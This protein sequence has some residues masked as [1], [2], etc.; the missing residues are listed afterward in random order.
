MIRVAFDIGGTFTDF[1]LCDDATGSTHALKVPTSSANPGE[2]VIEGLEKL[3]AETGARGSAVDVVLH[4][5][6][7]ATNAVLERKGAKTGLITTQGFRDVLIIGRQKRYETYDMYIDKSE[8]LVARRHIV[9]VVERVAPDGTVVTSLDKDSVQR[10]IDAMLTARRETVAVSLLHAYA[11]PEHERQIR[12]QFA[13]RAPELLISISSEISPKFREY[14]RTNT[15]VTNAYVKPIV[16]R[17]LR[18]L[19]E[20]LKAR[21]IRNDLFV[22]QSN[23]GLISPNLA[24]D[25]P[26]R[27]IES[28]PAAG[29]LMCAI[30]GR[31]EGRDQIITFDMGGTT[32]KLGAID[33]GAPAIMPTFEV[34]LVRYKKGSG[35]PINV[36]AVEMVEIG[37]GGG[38]IARDNKGMIVVG[39]DSAGADPG[40]LCYGRGGGEPT[41]TDANVVLGYISPEWFNGGAMRLDRDAAARGIRRAL[42]TP[43][44]V[45][46]EE[47]AWGIHLVATSNMENALRIVSVERGRDPRRYAMVAFGGAGPL[48]AARLARSVGIPTVIVP[49]GAG[50][51]SAMGLLQAEPRLDV[52]L[53]RVMQL[54]GKQSSQQIAAVYEELEALAR[55]DVQRISRAGAPQWSRYAQMRYAGQGFEIH[56]DL[57][58]GRIDDDYGQ[59]AVDAFKQAYL[60]RR[61]FLDPEGCVEVVDWTLVA[62]M[63]SHGGGTTLGRHNLAAKARRETR[64][65]WFPETGGYTDTAIV[66]RAALADG[67]TIVGPAIIEDP[68]CTALVLPG[69]TARMSKQGHIIIAIRSEASP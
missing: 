13:A 24:R 45:S 14:E 29:V 19:D 25:F 30:V 59:K 66:D 63:P 64:L 62:T 26:V 10:A 41:I 46:T 16:D 2:A 17:Y 38:S 27:I 23:G 3:L 39:P 50:V 15:T 33:D 58:P 54:D 47:A 51:G 61:K 9:E 40:P 57:P 18:H 31:E 49:Y 12:D 48:H 6:T 20:A 28:G 34:D 32:A 4:A 35:L 42:A 55:G 1:V 36:P 5:T 53:T 7:V 67:S 65:A 8:P 56:V 22:M 68:D 43:L 11:N 37:A 52:S 21:G 60:R 69:D 44:G